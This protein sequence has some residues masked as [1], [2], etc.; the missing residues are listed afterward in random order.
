MGGL[1]KEVAEAAGERR[2]RMA[3][4]VAA[5]AEVAAERVAPVEQVAG[6][7]SRFCRFKQL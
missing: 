1:G 7:A 6:R 5:D 2:H 3:V 4:A